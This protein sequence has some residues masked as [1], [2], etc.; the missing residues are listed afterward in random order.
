M[1]Y[2]K[3]IKLQILKQV[4]E[5]KG[6]D[7]QTIKLNKCLPATII[8]DFFV[9]QFLISPLLTM[10]WR[11]AWMLGDILM[12][13]VVFPEKKNLGII[14]SFTQ[15]HYSQ[16]KQNGCKSC[17]NSRTERDEPTK[18]LCNSNV[19]TYAQQRHDKYVNSQNLHE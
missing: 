15:L 18:N 12:D 3:L 9:G 5:S 6:A 13:Q 19:C 7:A 2:V 11:S 17:L 14:W 10:C 16:Q 4:A 8:T 1:H